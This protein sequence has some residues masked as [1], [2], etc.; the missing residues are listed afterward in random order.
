MSAIELGYHVQAPGNVSRLFASKG[1]AQSQ[2]TGSIRLAKRPDDP[3]VFNMAFNPELTR[4][5][6]NYCTSVVD[7]N[8]V[9]QLPSTTYFEN[10]IV[11]HL[12]HSTRSRVVDIGCGQG[13]FVEFL[14]EIGFA[15]EGFDP[16]LQKSTT[17]LHP[18]LWQQGEAEADLYIMRCVLPHLPD[19]WSFLKSLAE[20]SS[21]CLVLVEFQRLEWLLLNNLWY[22]ISHDHVNLFQI[23]DFSDRYEVI[24]SGELADGEWAWVLIDPS[25]FKQARPLD[26]DTGQAFS[27]LS[28]RRADFISSL[29]KEGRP[30]AIWGAAGKGTVL[31]HALAPVLKATFAFDADPLR[32]DL[33][34]E[35]SGIL[36]SSPATA[37]HLLPKETL[38]LVANPNHLKDVTCFIDERWE[39]SLP[40]DLG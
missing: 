9:K 37:T 34:M 16:V 3:Y 40:S 22:Q 27:A 7:I 26:T 39:I 21:G 32:W 31:S 14:R 18:R 6:R 12:S 2:P 29:A 1:Q 5:D 11:P 23:S 17:Y 13:E 4:Y 20:T 38:I 36:V 28:R 30:V 8:Q 10:Q 24:T 33:F 19:P 25:T 35:A 15:A